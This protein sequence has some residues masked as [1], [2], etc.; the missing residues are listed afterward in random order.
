VVN[1]STSVMRSSL[2]VCL[3]S[4]S[5]GR[6]LSIAQSTSSISVD[7][8]IGSWTSASAVIHRVI[9]ARSA[10]RFVRARC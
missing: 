5:A 10:V 6:D 1:G 4:T 2:T 7:C 9:T 3:A 8:A